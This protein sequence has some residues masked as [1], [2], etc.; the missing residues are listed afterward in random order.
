MGHRPT[1]LPLP[2]F[3]HQVLL[4]GALPSSPWTGRND[5]SRAW[6]THRPWSSPGFLR[7]SFQVP[8]DS[9]LPF[10]GCLSH[11][12]SLPSSG[13]TA[14]QSRAQTLSPHTGGPAAYTTAGRE[15]H[16]GRL[17]VLPSWTQ[18]AEGAAEILCHCVGLRPLRPAMHPQGRP[19]GW[20]VQGLVGSNALPARTQLSLCSCSPKGL[21]EWPGGAARVGWRGGQE[22]T[23]QDA[24]EWGL[25]YLDRSRGWWRLP[26]LGTGIRLTA[27]HPRGL[28]TFPRPFLLGGWPGRGTLGTGLPRPGNPS[29]PRGHCEDYRWA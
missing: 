22:S 6:D 19:A 1:P 20:L 10:P 2:H 18:G 9:A 13:L 16:P 4:P 12:H 21:A 5:S 26:S 29:P 28:S 14:W 8:Q 7:V 11:G 3:A 23:E 17:L 24:M 15:E 27:S 25:I